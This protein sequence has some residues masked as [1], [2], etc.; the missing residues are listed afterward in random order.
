MKS[1]SPLLFHGGTT[2]IFALF[3]KEAVSVL[4]MTVLPPVLSMGLL[5]ISMRQE[6]Q[7]QNA[8]FAHLAKRPLCLTKRF[9]CLEHPA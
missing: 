2:A 4:K 9:L 8:V 7:Q 5:S 3:G 1:C 6:P